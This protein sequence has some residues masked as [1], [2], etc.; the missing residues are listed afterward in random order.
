MFVW[1]LRT[2]DEM[3]LVPRKRH[4]L[5]KII[6]SAF[7][8]SKGAFFCY[9]G[10]VV[11]QIEKLTGSYF[12]EYFKLSYSKQ[13]H[14]RKLLQYKY[15]NWEIFNIAASVTMTMTNNG[16]GHLICWILK[17][18]HHTSWKCWCFWVTAPKKINTIFVLSLNLQVN[19]SV[20]GIQSRAWQ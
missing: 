20:S 16:S 19:H 5:R 4:S 8:I 11:H 15:W 12:P 18:I 14:R 3:F 17:P 2:A 13:D 1:A 6:T 7:F 10:N 9:T